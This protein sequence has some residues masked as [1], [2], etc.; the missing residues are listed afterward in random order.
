MRGAMPC[1]P[2]GIVGEGNGDATDQLPPEQRTL[3]PYE[4]TAGGNAATPS[5]MG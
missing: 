2:A 5:G 4:A 1:S 3:K